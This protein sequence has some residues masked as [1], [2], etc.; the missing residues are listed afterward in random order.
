MCSGW[1]RGVPARSPPSRRRSAATVSR[2]WPQEGAVRVRRRP[3]FRPPG[4]R[5]CWNCGPDPR[6][7][8]F[9]PVVLCRPATC[10][11]DRLGAAAPPRRGVHLLRPHQPAGR[12][13]RPHMRGRAIR[14]GDRA[15]AAPLARQAP[16]APRTRQPRPS[17]DRPGH[18][19]TPPGTPVHPRTKVTQG[20][21]ARACTCSR[22]S[23]TPPWPGRAVR[24]RPGAQ[25]SH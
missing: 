14:R 20:L 11:G 19:R 9:R 13:R 1:S 24:G 12:G 22:R 5:T 8:S 16:A 10:R 17:P 23:R 2:S 6:P 7:G 3:R 25:P 21:T 15:D 4:F 18:P